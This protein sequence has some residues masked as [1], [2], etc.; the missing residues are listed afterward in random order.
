MQ[1]ELIPD[2]DPESPWTGK[3]NNMFSRGVALIITFE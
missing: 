1:N 2:N 3:I